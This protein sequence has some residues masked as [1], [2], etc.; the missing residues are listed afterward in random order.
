MI[1]IF[2]ISMVILLSGCYASNNKYAPAV[3]EETFSSIDGKPAYSIKCY[4][5]E[6]YCVKA[7][8]SIC[9]ARGYDIIK[10]LHEY[11]TSDST[12]FI[13]CK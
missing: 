7:A 6:M 8:A 5:D 2:C 1:K 4:F 9:Q 10:K 11:N 3:V 13:Q 12:F